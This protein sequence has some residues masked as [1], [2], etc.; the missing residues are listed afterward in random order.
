M[1]QA[2]RAVARQRHAVGTF[3]GASVQTVLTTRT[4]GLV[5]L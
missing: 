5:D 2:A 3:N 1:Y 4:G